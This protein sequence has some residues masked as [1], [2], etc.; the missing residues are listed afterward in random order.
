MASVGCKKKL[1]DQLLRKEIVEV[2]LDLIEKDQPVTMA[3]V[4]KRCGVAKGTLYNYF[5][6]KQE[7]MEEVHTAVTEPLRDAGLAIFNGTGSSLERFFAFVDQIYRTFDGYA[8]YFRFTRRNLNV[9]EGFH[10]RSQLMIAPLEQ[11]YREGVANGEFIA[12]DS[13]LIAEML[14]GLIIGP[15]EDLPYRERK[16]SELKEMKQNV[17][18]LIQKFISVEK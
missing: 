4:A 11:L 13:Y 5:K 17:K 3:D 15:L 2:V 8:L 16:L 10:K 1:L 18:L 7:L 12:M 9:E 14:C 6:N